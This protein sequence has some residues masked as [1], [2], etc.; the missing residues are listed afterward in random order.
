MLVWEIVWINLSYN[1]FI[2]KWFTSHIV[3]N[4]QFTSKLL[5]ELFKDEFDG[6]K[7][8]TVHNAV[9]QL[10][11]TLKESP[12]GEDM[13]QLCKIDA[14]GSTLYRASYNDLSPEAVAYSIY[15][16]GVEKDSDMFRVADFYNTEETF[17]VAREFCIGKNDLYRKLR[18]LHSDSTH[19]L[20]AELNMGLDHITLNR[21]YSPIQVLEILAK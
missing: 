1:S 9:Y 15:K 6:Y 16:Y 2:V 3:A 17:G 20:T 11:R 8:I 14:K 18:F 12:I 4:Q 13:N 10:L 19:V 21:D 5:E 7:D